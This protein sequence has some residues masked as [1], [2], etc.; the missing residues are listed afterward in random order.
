MKLANA[1][2]QYRELAKNF[3]E[4]GATKFQLFELSFLRVPIILER[5]SGKHNVVPGKIGT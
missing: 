4:S 3:I 2:C 1:L 5:D